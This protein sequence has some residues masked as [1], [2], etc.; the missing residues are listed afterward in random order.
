MCDVRTA[1]REGDTYATCQFCQKEFEKLNSLYEHL[2]E[3]KRAKEC[4]RQIKHWEK[5]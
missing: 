4:K 5:R 2:K 3:C 1:T